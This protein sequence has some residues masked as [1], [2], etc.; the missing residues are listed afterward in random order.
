MD[1]KYGSMLVDGKRVDE[2]LLSVPFM[3]ATQCGELTG[4]LFDIAITLDEAEVET[5]EEAML[6]F[7]EVST[8]I[9]TRFD[10]FA[11]QVSDEVDA[12][13]A[14]GKYIRAGHNVYERHVNGLL[15]LRS[16]FGD[17]VT[18]VYVDRNYLAHKQLESRAFEEER[19]IQT[20][21]NSD[22]NLELDISGMNMLV[23]FTDGRLIEMTN[24]EWGMFTRIK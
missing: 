7:E 4:V 8:A 5:I 11:K 19:I 23:Q 18:E 12:G 3:N 17:L 6:G 9:N 22:E 1:N 13:V 14:S 10:F 24:S 15:A 20:T 16:I 2:L 21:I